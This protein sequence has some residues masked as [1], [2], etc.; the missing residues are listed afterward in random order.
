[1]SKLLEKCEQGID[2]VSSPDQKNENE[3]ETKVTEGTIKDISEKSSTRSESDSYDTII[4]DSTAQSTTQI[5]AESVTEKFCKSLLLSGAPQEISIPGVP[6]DLV[7][8]CSIEEPKVVL[9]SKKDNVSLPTPT[10]EVASN[11]TN[12]TN[13]EI[14][15]DAGKIKRPDISY[16]KHANELST[17]SE[18][19]TVS[20]VPIQVAESVLQ[21]EPKESVLDSETV[22]EQVL[23]STITPVHESNVPCFD[24][25]V[26]NKIQVN[27]S[28]SAIDSTQNK[29][30]LKFDVI[31]KSIDTETSQMLSTIEQA[32]FVETSALSSSMAEIAADKSSQVTK[33]ILQI[34]ETK[35]CTKETSEPIQ[36]TEQTKGSE[37]CAKKLTESTASSTECEVTKASPLR[38]SPVRPTRAKELSVPSKSVLET[39]QELKS[40]E[41]VTKKTAKKSLEKSTSEADSAETTE[42]DST[43]KKVVKKVVKKV[44][45]KSKSKPGEAPDDGAEECSSVGKQKKTVK[46]VKKGTKSSQTS[47][48]DTTVPE[49]PSSSTSDTPVPPKRKTKA[50]TTKPVIK[51]SDVE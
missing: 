51:K 39:S 13:V 33:P 7:Q 9:S 1:M 41:K 36:Q 16:E 22:T 8:S 20:P 44:G 30:K 25:N 21:V 23:S 32:Q 12:V 26:E 4:D 48:T 24:T 27:G 5:S 49:T 2:T 40:Q 46:L 6:C 43:G 47:E 37:S 28:A 50:T 14:G 17:A 10:E 3:N 18:V 19:L 45:K 11:V 34:Q 35:S 31:E 29:E 42:G 38:E 15:I